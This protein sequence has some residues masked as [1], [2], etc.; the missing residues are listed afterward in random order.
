MYIYFQPYDLQQTGREGDPIAFARDRADRVLFIEL[1]LTHPEQVILP[2]Q[3]SSI[4]FLFFFLQ[5]CYT[6]TQEILYTL[7]R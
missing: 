5:I 3:R 4:F 7:S 1:V 2:L 6:L